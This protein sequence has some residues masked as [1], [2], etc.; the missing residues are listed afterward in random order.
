MLVA[1]SAL[2]RLFAPYLPF[3]TEEVW[4]WWRAGSVHRQPWPTAA[5]L[6]SA[7]SDSANSAELL[8]ATQ[9]VLARVRGAKSAQKLS[10]RAPVPLVTVTGQPAQLE[11]LAQARGD[12]VH[13]GRIE[14]LDLRP[15]DA[16]D[17]STDLTVHVEL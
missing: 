8:A 2:L 15:A 4:S 13:A 6:E 17:G 14:N 3:V 12:L 10:M 1:L 16:P 9:A 5:E 7:V 11:L